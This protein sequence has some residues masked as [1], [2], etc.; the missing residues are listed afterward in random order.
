[1]KLLLIGV[2]RWGRNHLKALTNLAD[3][4]YVVNADPSQL[5]A[6][7]E[8]SIPEDHLSVNYHDFLDRID[9]VDVVTPAD[10]HLAICMDCFRKGKDVFV[11]KPI[12]LTSQEAREMREEGRWVSP[13]FNRKRM[14]LSC[15]LL[16]NNFDIRKGNSFRSLGESWKRGREL[17]RF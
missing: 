7:R 13:P 17:I 2:G 9:G 12:V 1:M 15:W 4:L 14:V 11:E 5:K 10:S 8:F 3:E 6:C 16:S